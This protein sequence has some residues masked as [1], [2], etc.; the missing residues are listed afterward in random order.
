LEEQNVNYDN[1]KMNW[2]PRFVPIRLEQL[3]EIPGSTNDD[4]MEDSFYWEVG[5]SGGGDSG[6]SRKTLLTANL[7]TSF[8]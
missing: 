3:D 7:N 1:I 2:K 6:S 5:D 4:G 8:R